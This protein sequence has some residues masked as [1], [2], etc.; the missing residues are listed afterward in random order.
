MKKAWMCCLL[1]VLSLGSA[2][3]AQAQ[4]TGATEK[5]VAAMENQW[6]ESQKTNNVD[7]LAPLLADKLVNTNTEGK[8]TNRGETL[9]NAKATKFSS[10]EYLDLHVTAF[11]DTAIATGTFKGKGTDKT[12][13]PFDQLERFTDTWVKMPGGK[14]QCV[15][16]HGSDIKK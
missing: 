9:A 16:T 10:V 5:A 1:G 8:V 14:W 13:K 3:G 7:L 4:D 2:T 6:L 12:G 11:G 15:A